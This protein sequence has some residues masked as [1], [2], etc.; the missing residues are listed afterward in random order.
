MTGDRV[1]TAVEPAGAL[2]D[3]VQESPPARLPAELRARVA[4]FVEEH[5]NWDGVVMLGDGAA[6]HWVHVSAG[7][8][9]SMMGFLTPRLVAD[10]G[11]AAA[12]DMAAVSDTMSRP[13]RLA[14]QLRSAEVAGDGSALTGHLIGAELAA[15]KVYWL[16]QQVVAL[17]Q[18]PYA[19]MLR[20]QGVSV[21][22]V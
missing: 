12:P 1:P 13:E 16:G 5:P 14:A 19:E 2:R 21:L 17:S 11:G 9:I 18:G 10:L 8:A 6:H 3:L 15:A 20:A 4:G 7:E 22:E